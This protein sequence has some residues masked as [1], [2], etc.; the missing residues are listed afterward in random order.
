MEAAALYSDLEVVFQSHNWPHWG[1]AEIHEYL[2]DTAAI[3]KFI[4][5][6]TLLLANQG[7]TSVEIAEMITL[8]AELEQVWYTRQYYGTLNHNAKAVYQKFLG[9]YDANPAN[10]NPLPPEDVAKKT[11]EYMGGAEA[12]MAKALSDFAKGEYRWVAEV[13]MAVIFADPTNTAAR[14]LCADALEQLGYQAES[15]VWRAAYLTGAQELREGPPTKGLSS[16][17]GGDMTRAMTA[18]MVF[19]YLGIYLDSTKAQ[20][21]SFTMNV[22]GADDNVYLV[23][24]KNGVLLYQVGVES[25]TADV[26]VTVP[27]G[28]VALL[29]APDR[30]P[31]GAL[32]VEGNQAKFAELY[33]YLVI[34]DPVFNI[35]EP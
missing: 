24:V 13:T 28:G 14:Y 21:L 25:T 10:L 20:D 35:V 1:N 23:T 32:K 5:D 19:D 18:T 15:G 22:R 26:T 6:Q 31:A 3:Y 12:V 16:N 34:P 8:P 33:Q 29:L 27:A 9:W 30:A 11:V 4:N 7:F 2:L 17:R